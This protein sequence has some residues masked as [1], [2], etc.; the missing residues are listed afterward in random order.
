M[1]MD[2]PHRRLSL[3]QPSGLRPH[4]LSP[5]DE[6]VSRVAALE[7]RSAELERELSRLAA[8]TGQLSTQPAA[9]GEGAAP[10]GANPR[11]EPAAARLGWLLPACA[12]FSA[13]GAALLL[14]WPE[15]PQPHGAAPLSARAGWRQS[16]S[17]AV[18]AP[19]PRFDAVESSSPATGAALTLPAAD[20]DY[21]RM[22]PTL[23]GGAGANR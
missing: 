17:L 16:R 19:A 22:P 21:D 15:K 2:R 14:L 6:A 9:S 23:P 13:G 8:V 1:S 5:L 4:D 11:K 20:P 7:E 12:A 10:C 18:P 3:T